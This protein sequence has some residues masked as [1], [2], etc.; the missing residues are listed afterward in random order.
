MKI[1]IER[2]NGCINN[3]LILRKVK[4]YCFFIDDH[5]NYFLKRTPH[6]LNMAAR[7]IIE[8]LKALGT[9][10]AIEACKE[11]IRRGRTYRFT[12]SLRGD[13][14]NHIRAC[15]DGDAR[16]DVAHAST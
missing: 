6:F 7:I 10:T 8:I 2:E 11:I 4:L 3:H 9:W 1:R 12:I 16:C 5:L 15:P 14:G 13:H